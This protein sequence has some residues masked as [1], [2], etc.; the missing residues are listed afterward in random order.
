[1]GTMTPEKWERAILA[2]LETVGMNP[3][4]EKT[5]S[6]YEVFMR[7]LTSVA[8]VAAGEPGRTD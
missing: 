8:I 2:V 7:R 4:V 5:P 3:A 1:M 6:E